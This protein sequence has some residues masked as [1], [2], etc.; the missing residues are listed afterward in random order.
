MNQRLQQKIDQLEQETIE[1]LEATYQIIGQSCENGSHSVRIT[2][3]DVTE[4]LR[5]AIENSAQSLFDEWRNTAFKAGQEAAQEIRRVAKLERE[6]RQWEARKRQAQKWTFF[7]VLVLALMLVAMGF[8][9]WRI[10]DLRENLSQARQPA[11]L[12]QELRRE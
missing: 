10:N 4:Q 9:T 7:F 12:I 11:D 6:A 5:Q 8:L 3:S 1:S 2:I